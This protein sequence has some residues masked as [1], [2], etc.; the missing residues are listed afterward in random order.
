MMAGSIHGV[1]IAQ[2]LVTGLLILQCGQ[3][4]CR[5]SSNTSMTREL[6]LACGLKA[7]WLTQIQIYTVPIQNGFCMKQIAHRLFGDMN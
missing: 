4:A 6:S 3:M 2:V 7:R 1:M 5:Q